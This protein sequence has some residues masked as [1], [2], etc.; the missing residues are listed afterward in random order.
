MTEPNGIFLGFSSQ[1]LLWKIDAPSLIPPDEGEGTNLKS[2]L[3]RLPA[4]SSQTREKTLSD[5]P[6]QASGEGKKEK[7][8]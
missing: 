5:R 7:K 2:P 8:T 3:A 4:L 6:K 1:C